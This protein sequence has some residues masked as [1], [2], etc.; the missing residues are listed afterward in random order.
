MALFGHDSPS[1]A[2]ITLSPTLKSSL[3]NTPLKKKA[4]RQST[5]PS[6]SAICLLQPA[7]THLIYTLHPFSTTVRTDCHCTIVPLANCRWKFKPDES[8]CSLPR[9]TRRIIHTTSTAQ[10][11]MHSHLC[12]TRNTGGE[13]GKWHSVRV[14]KL[15][16]QHRQQKQRASGKG[17]N[18]N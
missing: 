5:T 1:L 9:V 14:R 8:H 3:F 18:E 11:T 17:I 4:Y 15:H 7:S 10:H 12:C 16:Q 13:K 6:R 2:I